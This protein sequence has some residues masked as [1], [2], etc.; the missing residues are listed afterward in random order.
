[1]FFKD[2]QLA[3]QQAIDSNQLNIDQKSP[4]YAGK[5]MYMHSD[6]SGDHFKNIDSREYMLVKVTDNTEK[7]ET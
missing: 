7:K 3:F 6:E 1:M 4:L 2:S 5:W